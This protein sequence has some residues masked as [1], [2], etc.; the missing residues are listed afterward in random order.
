MTSDNRAADAHGSHVRRLHPLVD[1]TIRMILTKRRTA[2]RI[3][4]AK[5]RAPRGAMEAADIVDER[6]GPLAH[7]VLE[8]AS[9]FPQ[10]PQPS[11]SG[12]FRTRVPTR[13]GHSLPAALR[14]L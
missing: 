9:R 8:N 3:A 6:N 7:N 14:G 2:V 11:S 10:L 12:K 13:A 1:Q 4:S 5:T